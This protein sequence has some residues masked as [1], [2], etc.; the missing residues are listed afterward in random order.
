MATPPPPGI[1][2]E[3][4]SV[5]NG[6][7][8]VD[9]R[10][11]AMQAEIDAGGGGG[12]SP[13]FPISYTTGLQTA[14]DGKQPLDAD[15]TAIAALSGSNVLIY[16]AGDGSWG[17]VTVAGSLTFSGGILTG[18]GGGSGGGD[19]YGP[20]T[21]TAD[22]LPQWNGANSKTLKNGRAIGVASA[23][24]IPDRAAAD[25][26]YQPV[27][28]YATLA[29]PTFTGTPAAPTATAGTSTTQLAT[30]AFVTT[31]DNLKAPIA[32]PTFTGTPAAPTATAGTSTT[33]LATTA[34]VTTA[35]NLKA[36]LASPALTGTPTAPTASNGTNTTQIATTAFVLA[37]AG[38]GG[39][40][41]PLGNYTAT[42][43]PTVNDDSAD[44]YEVGSRWFNTV[45]SQ[46]WT[47]RVVTV[48][49]A[50]WVLE[51]LADHPGYIS[52]NW[53]HGNTGVALANGAALTANTVRMIPF[54]FKTR[55]TIS[56]LATRITTASSGGNIQLAIYDHNSAT[57]FPTG[58]ARAT[59]ASISTT[60]TGPQPSTGAPLVAGDTTFEAGIYWL[61]VNS[62][63][64]TVICQVYS[65]A[66]VVAGYMIGSPALS[67]VTGAGTTG[68]LALS[69]ATQTFGTW[70]DLT[71]AT[72]TRIGSN[73][74]TIPIFKVA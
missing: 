37:N 43:A 71:S 3:S 66:Q 31:A 28:S 6:F 39:G 16:R 4:L 14:L 40:G 15:L 59:T 72:F 35:D 29:S 7:R 74:Y 21:N 61:A 42:T 62:D 27:G 48:G 41:A 68:T 34:F 64:S 23:T 73:G 44:G 65:T 51:D 49:A 47:A 36:P 60:A 56:A 25:T 38:G 11:D 54:V 10:L 8:A 32:S 45:T 33:Q 57:G 13:P 9:T 52:G 26:R 55:V 22:Y 53:Y 1:A 70:N 17:P 5:F 2:A 67:D 58:L 20:A 18:T 63:N 24:D 46:M 50:V 69:V 19:V 12:V 30:T